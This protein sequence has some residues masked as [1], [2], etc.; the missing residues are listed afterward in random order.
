MMISIDCG[1]VE[2]TLEIATFSR[3]HAALDWLIYND[4]RTMIFNVPV[5]IVTR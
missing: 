5:D 3:V 4:Q 1:A 2:D